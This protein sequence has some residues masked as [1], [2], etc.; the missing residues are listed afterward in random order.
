MAMK[1]SNKKSVSV[2]QSPAPSSPSSVAASQ[3]RG[4]SSSSQGMRSV[5]SAA[6]QAAQVS[7]EAIAGRAY[8]IWKSGKGGSELQNWTQAEKE[9]R[10]GR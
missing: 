9:L 3:S 4:I 7:L 10:S 1:R 8:Q 2:G 6:P 5:V